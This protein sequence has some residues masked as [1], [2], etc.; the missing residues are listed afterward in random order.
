M[1]S[2]HS[3]VFTCEHKRLKAAEDSGGNS[4]GI[5]F[6]QLIDREV[7]VYYRTFARIKAGIDEVV[8]RG[9]R[10]RGNHL[11]AEVIEYEKVALEIF[12]GES[13]L[14]FELF[15]VKIVKNVWGGI[16]DHFI[17]LFDNFF[18]N[19]GGEVGLAETG[20]AN[21]YKIG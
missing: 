2:L 21:E 7:C 11:G 13:R 18:C 12:V 20:R 17:P 5:G 19:R 10:K 16:V 8:E 4:V 3:D 14:V 6:S 15:F 1:Q 9:Y